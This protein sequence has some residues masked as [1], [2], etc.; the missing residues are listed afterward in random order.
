MVRDLPS[1]QSGE[2]TDPKEPDSTPVH[3]FH[4]DHQPKGLCPGSVC[5]YFHK[6]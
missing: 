6:T 1:L 3:L 5:C 2:D 4:L